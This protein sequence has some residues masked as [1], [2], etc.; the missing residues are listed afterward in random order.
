MIQLLMAVQ[1]ALA[2]DAPFSAPRL[3]PL[4]QLEEKVRQ[5]Q[6]GDQTLRNQVI[7]DC[8]PYIKGV[9]NRMLQMPMIEHSDEY[10]IA[11]SAFDEAID[12]YQCETRVPFL[13]FAGLV[14][15]RRV[16]DWLRQQRHHRQSHPFSEFTDDQGE[17]TVDRLISCPPDEIWQNMEV[18][19]E[20][21]LLQ[22]RLQ[23]FGLSM[24]LLARKL[25]KHRDSR[26]MCL[27]AARITMA[28]PSLRSRFEQ[29]SRLPAAE[30]ARRS[31]IPLKT[32]ERNRPCIIF[33]ALLLDSGLEVIKAYL[34]AYSQSDK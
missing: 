5:I 7:T 15:N 18:E 22:R 19:E 33:L 12:R 24:A 2:D 25:P 31:G 6:S 9:L 34:Y 27:K 23:G 8:L 26:L 14:I 20:L 16:I 32:I 11:L 29:E 28:D 1:D 21:V 13:R 3:A 17:S 30:L 4:S 10:S